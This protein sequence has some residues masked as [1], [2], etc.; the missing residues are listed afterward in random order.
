MCNGKVERRIGPIREG[1][2][3][4]VEEAVHLFPDIQFPTKALTLDAIYPEA[5]AWMS[6]CIKVLAQLDQ[7]PHMRCPNK[8]PYHKRPLRAPLPFL[9]PVF[10]HA[11]RSSKIEAKAK[12]CFYL[13]SS[14]G[15]SQDSYK[16]LYASGLARY[17]TDVFFGYSRRPRFS[18]VVATYG[19][20]AA[21]DPWADGGLDK[22]IAAVRGGGSGGDEGRTGG[23]GHGSSGSSSVIPGRRFGAGLSDGR[24]G[25]GNGGGGSGGGGGGGDGGDDDA[26]GVQTWVSDRDAPDSSFVIDPDR[27]DPDPRRLPRAPHMQTQQQRHQVTPSVT[28]SSARRLAAAGPLPRSPGVLVML[29]MAE[30]FDA[31]MDNERCYGGPELPDGPASE[32]VTPT[33][34]AEAHSGEDSDIWYSAEDAEFTEHL[35]AETFS[36]GRLAF[37]QFKP[38][39]D[40]YIRLPK[41]CGSLSGK[42]VKLARSLYGLNQA[43]RMWHFHLFRAMKRLGFEQCAADAC[44]MR[45]TENGVVTRCWLKLEDFGDAEPGVLEPFRSLVGHLMWLANRTRPDILN[46]ARVVAR[47]AVGLGITYQ[48]VT[49]G[50]VSFYLFVASDYASNATDR[51]SVSG[52]VVMCAGACVS[53]SSRT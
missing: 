48:H 11:R 41:G 12:R 7:K 20:G 17:T 47:F 39:K 30:D 14:V 32:R 40:V 33:A 34:L 36:L 22:A 8:L 6:D 13:N 49:E 45:L 27:R 31:W 18:G 28:R 50:G 3:A 26:R 42:A 51:P 35:E 23:G 1:G 29:A 37:V 2:R 9:M 5:F 38:E 15:H 53:F 10:H 44:V 52:A 43:C 19:G 24:S 16:V 4:T 25:G 46:A 21:R